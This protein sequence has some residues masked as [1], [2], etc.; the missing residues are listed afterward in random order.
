[1]SALNNESSAAKMAWRNGEYVKYLM[2]A[3]LA[4]KMAGGS[5]GG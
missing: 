5:L 4:A 3:Y 1:M 2:A